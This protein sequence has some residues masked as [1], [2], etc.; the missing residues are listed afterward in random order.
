MRILIVPI[1]RIESDFVLEYLCEALKISFPDFDFEISSKTL[2]IP[3][4]SYNATRRQYFSTRLLEELRTT[5]A[6][7]DAG[8][9]LGVTEVDLFVPHLNFV[10]GEAECPGKTCLISLARLKPEFYYQR[11]NLQ[12]FKERALKEAIH[13]L[14]HTFQ[15]GHCADP[16]C[17]MRFSN[18]IFDT[19]FKNPVFC[20]LCFT[21]LK[22]NI[23][24]IR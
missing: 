7:A 18:S 5:F 11:S 3:P 21:K 9:V 16:K 20:P 13:E 4:D 6:F 2:P 22:S 23:A 1:G 12:L 10:F 19:D 24:R 14:G 15:L 8:K 17:V